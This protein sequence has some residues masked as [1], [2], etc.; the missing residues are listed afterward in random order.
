MQD[1]PEGCAN[2]QSGII[3]QIFCQK[4]HENEKIWIPGDVPAPSPPRSANDYHS[5]G[6]LL[7]VW[8]KQKMS[9]TWLA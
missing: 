2:S 5:N 1:F 6:Y 4:L 7:S 9:L 3:L 8:V